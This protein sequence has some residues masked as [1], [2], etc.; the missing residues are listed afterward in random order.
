MCGTDYSNKNAGKK[1]QSQRTEELNKQK[2]QNKILVTVITINVMVL[3]F[4]IK[5]QIQF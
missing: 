3:S 2:T 5:C 1:K 4:P